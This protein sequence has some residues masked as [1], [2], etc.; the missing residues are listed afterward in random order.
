M[1]KLLIQEPP[2]QV[3][4]SL[5]VKVGLKE[6]IILQQIHYWILSEKSHER[7]GLNWIYNTYEGWQEQ[8]PYM[9]A[10]SLRNAIMELEKKGLLI[11]ANYNEKKSDR[12][13]WYTIDYA[14]LEIFSEKGLPKKAD[15]LTQNGMSILPKKVSSIL[16]KKVGS[17]ITETT[18]DYNREREETHPLKLTEEEE[19]Q[20]VLGEAEDKI[21]DEIYN[22]FSV[23]KKYE[24]IRNLWIRTWSRNAKNPEVEETFKLI[25][26]HG[27]NGT[28]TLMREGALKNFKNFHNFIDAIEGG[29]IKPLQASNH[30]DLVNRTNKL[31]GMVCALCGSDKILLSRDGKGYC[32]YE[33]QDKYLELY[34]ANGYKSLT[35][36]QLRNVV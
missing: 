26:K 29:K 36:D 8:F 21:T 10:R 20:K 35:Q 22:S 34:E 13:K 15:G 18:R 6:A 31:E 19:L 14:K 24:A 2:L 28:Y 4:P 12:T 3:L 1:S 23:T 27:F 5:A 17:I 32:S 30:D 7:D 11:S 16:P 9:T 33:H 25:K